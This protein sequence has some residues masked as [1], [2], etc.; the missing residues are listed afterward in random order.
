MTEL[1]DSVD[2][3]L[4]DLAKEAFSNGGRERV[5]EALGNWL[6]FTA[7]KKPAAD[8]VK[9]LEDFRKRIEG[10]AENLSLDIGAAGYV[11]KTTG[12]AES[13]LQMLE[14][15]TEWFDPAGDLTEMI[16]GAIFEQRS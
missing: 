5:A 16:V 8:A 12:D 15:G 10:L 14:R 1:E 11:V 9:R 2:E 4:E 7:R 6:A 3:W 13:T